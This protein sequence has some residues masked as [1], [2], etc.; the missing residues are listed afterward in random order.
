MTTPI[1]T[2]AD[3]L[4]EDMDIL[5]PDLGG[6]TQDL[7]TLTLKKKKPQL[8]TEETIPGIA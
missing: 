3:F 1:W 7:Q 4:Q 6:G 5:V 8:E 2:D